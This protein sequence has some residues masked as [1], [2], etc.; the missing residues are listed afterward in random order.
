MAVPIFIMDEMLKRLSELVEHELVMQ[1]G[2]KDDFNE[3]TK[4]LGTIKEVLQDTENKELPDRTVQRWLDELR[5]V[6]YDAEDIIDDCSFDIHVNNNNNSSSSLMTSRGTVSRRHSFSSLSRLCSILKTMAVFYK[7]GKGVVNRHDIEKRIQEINGRLEQIQKKRQL[8]QFVPTFPTEERSSVSTFWKFQPPETMMSYDID[9]NIIG[10]DGDTE[11][12][13]QLLTGPTNGG[14]GG[15]FAIVGMAGIGKTTLAKK[16]FNNDRI[17]SHFEGKIWVCVSKDY[18]EADVLK[19]IIRSAGEVWGE[20]QTK[21]ELYSIVNEAFEGRRI[22]L[23]LDELWDGGLK[24]VISVFTADTRV[25]ITTRNEEIARQMGG[26]L[27]CTH[28]MKLLSHN[29]AWSLLGKARGGFSRR[30]N[31]CPSLMAAKPMF[32]SPIVLS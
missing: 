18:E 26:S 20:A 23:V 10:I 17:K 32:R 4:N 13:V 21:R 3:L 28:E 1:W 11:R 27:I 5:D 31:D 2:V 9:S 24:S 30:I 29:D 19:R 22:L 8:I 12:L 16:V 7:K 15:V 25:L 14:G 6:M